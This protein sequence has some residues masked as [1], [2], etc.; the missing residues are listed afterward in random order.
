[1]CH[2]DGARMR[3]V[4]CSAGRDAAGAHMVVYPCTPYPPTKQPVEQL[5]QPTGVPFGRP[6]QRSVHANTATSTC[7]CV[8]RGCHAGHAGDKRATCPQKGLNA[9]RH[10]RPLCGSPRAAAL[11]QQERDG[12]HVRPSFMFY[13]FGFILVESARARPLCSST[14]PLQ[15]PTT[16]VGADVEGPGPGA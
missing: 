12:P 6:L 1:M 16:A 4:G 11:V 15:L 7:P 9:T 2:V 5:V 14:P 10:F 8:T 3:D 13:P